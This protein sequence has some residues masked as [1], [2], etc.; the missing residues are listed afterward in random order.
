[1]PARG[2]RGK[3]CSSS[4]PVRPRGRMATR[5]SST[6]SGTISI[7][8][9]CTTAAGN[10]ARAEPCPR[11]PP[12]GSRLEPPAR[13]RS[14]PRSQSISNAATSVR[15]PSRITSAPPPRR[16]GAAP[17]PRRSHHLRRA[18]DAIGHIADDVER[19]RVEVELRVAMGAAFMA[20]RGF[21]APE[22]LEAYSRAEAL[23]DRLGER[24][25]LFPA[26]WGQW[27]FRTGRGEMDQASPAGREADCAWRKIRRR[28]AED[29]GPSRHVV[30]LVR[31]R[32]TGAGACA[33]GRRPWR[34]TMPRCIRPWPR[35]MATTMP[36][37]ARAIS[38][39]WRWR[40]RARSSARAR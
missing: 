6:P 10:A 15:A 31:V 5:P 28:R 29:P 2:W 9:C 3:A 38:A 7:A 37:A 14:Q 34:S 26:I 20:T 18:L 39:R 13:M 17:T 33:R 21:G 23:C 36:A 4:S 1:M 16:S 24:A 32:R 35:A 40:S 22:V 30:D 8:S 11:R 25:D 12:A 19:A 27:M